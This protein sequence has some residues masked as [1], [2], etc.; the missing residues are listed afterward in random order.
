MRDITAEQFETEVIAASAQ[1][2]VVV[3]F[4]APWCGPCHQLSP[5]LERVAERYAGEVDAVK[6]N[7]DNAPA[8]AQRFGIQGIPAVKAFKD[9]KVVGEFVGVQP[10]PAIEQLFSGL[11][12]SPADRLADQALD[13]G[14]DAEAESLFRQALDLQRD[15]APAIVGLARLL[16][17]R[18]DDEEAR[19]L[20]ARAPQ[21][22]QTR[23]LLAEVELGGAADSDPDALRAAAAAG[24]A[25]AALQLGRALAARED[26]AEALPALLTAVRD[27]QTRDDA[28]SSM[29]TVFALLGDDSEA[30][31]VWRP[32]LAAALF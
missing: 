4:W 25:T 8:V 24:D 17:A 27:P 31:R 26:Y 9:G 32:K 6:L 12:P 23:R 10:E 20:L 18:G 5:L 1:R 15:H 3:D 16:L 7:V 22:P 11:G 21:D 13:A 14:D 19:A 2:P 28:R 30:V 29:L